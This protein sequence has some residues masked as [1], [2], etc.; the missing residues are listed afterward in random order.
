MPPRQIGFRCVLCLS[1]VPLAECRLLHCCKCVSSCFFPHP[2]FPSPD[3]GFCDPCMREWLESNRVGPQ[4]RLR[5]LQCPTCR[6]PARE[7]DLGRMFVETIVLDEDAEYQTR[8]VNTITEQTNSARDSVQ[9]ITPTSSTVQVNRAISGVARTRD[10]LS[11]S[12]YAENEPIV[13][14]VME[15]SV[16]YI[17]AC[18]RFLCAGRN[19]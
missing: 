19:C 17:I 12:Q 3:H 8:L 16:M 1:A 15:V 4:R 13:K 11:Q 5:Q 7:S 10:V 6:K 9:A 18:V 2:K 14:T